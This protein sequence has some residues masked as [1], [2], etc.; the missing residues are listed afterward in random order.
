MKQTPH[1]FV[2]KVLS[3]SG[4]YPPIAGPCSK[5]KTLSSHLCEKKRRLHSR[6]PC[7]DHQ[8]RT[9]ATPHLYFSHVNPLTSVRESGHLIRP[10]K[11]QIPKTK[12]QTFFG[13]LA[14][15]SLVFIWICLPVAVRVLALWTFH[16]VQPSPMI[17]AAPLERS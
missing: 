3:S 9:F 15:W 2:G 1:E 4:K 10:F 8:C 16:I 11:F 14:N 7:A 17:P 12:F 6:N 5:R 13:S